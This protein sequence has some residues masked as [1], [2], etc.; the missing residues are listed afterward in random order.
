MRL[1]TRVRFPPPPLGRKG[2]CSTAWPAGLA[3]RAR[4]QGGV[5]SAI[6]IIR[7]FLQALLV[8]LREEDFERVLSAAVA[9][10]AVGTMVYT[11]G[12]GWSPVDGFYFAVATLTPSTI[13]DPELTITDP[14]LKIFTAFYILIGIGILVEVV[15]RLGLGFIGAREE[16]REAKAARERGA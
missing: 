5:L 16:M 9:L 15:R 7:R 8:A 14:W 13:G 10:I 6:L 12:S 3:C 1:R 4:N 2:P 11:F